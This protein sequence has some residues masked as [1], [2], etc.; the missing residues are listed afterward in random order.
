MTGTS[1]TDNTLPDIVH[2]FPCYQIAKKYMEIQHNNKHS[3]ILTH[4][5]T[6]IIIHKVAM[7]IL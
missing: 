2:V 6:S 5:K 7:F 1:A 3:I 4:T